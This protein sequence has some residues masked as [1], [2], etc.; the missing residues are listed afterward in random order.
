MS[1]DDANKHIKSLY[2]NQAQTREV[3]Y[4]ALD[5]ARIVRNLIFNKEPEAIVSNK[6]Q[7]EKNSSRIDELIRKLDATSKQDEDVQFM[8]NIKNARKVYN[9]YNVEMME[10]A[11]KEGASDASAKVLDGSKYQLQAELLQ[12]LRDLVDDQQKQIEEMVE[13]AKMAD[14]SGVVLA[15]LILA[16]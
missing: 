12:S 6:N 2:I 1:D 11:M 16:F 7:Y 10:L 13:E 5:S 8:N 9:E 14:S 4:L 15:R 3:S